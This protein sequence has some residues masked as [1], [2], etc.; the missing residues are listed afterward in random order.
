MMTQM[1]MEIE[2]SLSLFRGTAEETRCDIIFS[3]HWGLRD[4]RCLSQ[5][6]AVYFFLSQCTFLAWRTLKIGIFWSVL[7][8]L[9]YFVANLCIFGLLFTALNS[10]VVYQT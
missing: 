10:P 9:G 6:A 3:E 5:P 1:R 4:S 7:A 8:N 2:R